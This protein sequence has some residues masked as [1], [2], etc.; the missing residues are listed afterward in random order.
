MCSSL[1]EFELWWL[2]LVK[3]SSFKK[4]DLALVNTYWVPI[5]KKV[6]SLGL[7]QNS[8][9]KGF[10]WKTNFQYHFYQRNYMHKKR[11]K[12]IASRKWENL[13]SCYCYTTESNRQWTF[14]IEKNH[15]IIA[16]KSRKNKN[17]AQILQTQNF[18]SIF[19]IVILQISLES[20][21]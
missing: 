2:K 7:F 20:G 8:N 12:E 21:N 13:V 11:R 19:L 3:Y 5:I 17:S 1:A 10:H 15:V 4:L 9:Q 16:H 18:L 14:T 6:K